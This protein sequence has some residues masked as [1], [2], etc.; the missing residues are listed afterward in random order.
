MTV[1]ISHDDD[2]ATLTLNRPERR[3]AL[4]LATVLALQAALDELA[5]DTGVRVVVV[6]GAGSAFCS[7]ADLDAAS[8]GGDESFAGDAAGAFADVLSAMV[9]HPKPIIARVQGPVAGGGNG[10]VAACDLAVATDS[11][12]FAF[13]EVRLGVVP[14]VIAPYVLRKV[15]PSAASELMLTGDRVSA[16]MAREAGLVQRVVRGES[17][18]ATVQGWVSQ[19]RRG[20]PQAL[21]VTKRVLTRVPTLSRDEARSWTTVVSAAAFR[22]D[23][24]QEGFAAYADRIDPS[25]VRRGR[26]TP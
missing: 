9:D 5:A 14:A 19:L 3:N 26:T 20:G 7:G 1:R 17:L 4:D 8:D 18:D 23:E 16:E 6:T 15:T 25:W 10:L 22:S 11:A 2:V 13:T 21:A 24:A 12:W